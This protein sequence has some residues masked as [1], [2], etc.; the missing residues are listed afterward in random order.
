[1]RRNSSTFESNQETGVYFWHGGLEDG[2]EIQ[3][4]NRPHELLPHHCKEHGWYS[5]K[6]CPAEHKNEPE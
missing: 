6:P 4:S 2:T 3:Y 1:M 5:D